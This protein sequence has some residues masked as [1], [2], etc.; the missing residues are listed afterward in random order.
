MKIPK[1]RIGHYRPGTIIVSSKADVYFIAAALSDEDDDVFL[2]ERKY[3][4]Q[5]KALD[6][7]K[8]WFERNTP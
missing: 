1:A 4:D 6:F 5:G 3:A 7:A 8:A 2:S